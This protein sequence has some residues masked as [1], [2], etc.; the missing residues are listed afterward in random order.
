MEREALAIRWAIK[1]RRKYLVCGPKFKIVTDHKLLTYMFHK[2][3]EDLPPRV[4]KF[5][6]DVQEQQQANTSV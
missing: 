3:S 1:K 6:M 2:Q 4:E 5:V